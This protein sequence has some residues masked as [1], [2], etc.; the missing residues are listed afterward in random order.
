FGLHVNHGV[1]SSPKPDSKIE[2]ITSLTRT[3]ENDTTNDEI[4]K[5]FKEELWPK[6]AVKELILNFEEVYENVNHGNLTKQHWEKVVNVVNV[7]CGTSLTGIQCKYKWN[8]LRK[9]FKREKQLEN[10][11][12]AP[13]STWMFYEDMNRIILTGN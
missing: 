6:Q 13:L 8:R 4:K 2:E 10:T 1:D 7:R 3:F 5:E 12:G 9:T 11:T